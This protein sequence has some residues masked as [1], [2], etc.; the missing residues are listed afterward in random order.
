MFSFFHRK[1]KESFPFDLLKTDV[2]SHLLPG[3]DDGSPNVA[4]S[5]ELIKGMSALGFQGFTATPHVM[6]DIWKNDDQTI[7]TAHGILK[8][9][10]L[11]AN[12]HYPVVAAAEYLVDGNLEKLLSQKIALRTIR[13]N[14][15]LIEIS[16]LQAPIQLR[17]ILFE[18]Q[19]QG[20][21]PVLA[22]PE[23]YLYYAQQPKA[24]ME[25]KDAGCILQCNLLSFAGYYGKEVKGFAEKLVDL[26]LIQLLGSDLHHERHMEALR[27][28]PF[29]KSLQKAME[30]IE[31]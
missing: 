30:I 15:V 8:N 26:Q 16:F 2:H 31:N 12:L 14:W 27:L 21:Q 22:H 13:K 10:M 17:N 24:L 23:R 5:L 6:E 11:D 18:M 9:A 3:I 4:T 1:Y 29:T 28:L 19:L 25:L 20:Y 7:N